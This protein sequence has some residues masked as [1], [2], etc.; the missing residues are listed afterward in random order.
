[1]NRVTLSQ[2]KALKAKAQAR[3][4]KRKANASFIRK[5]KKAIE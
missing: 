2:F 3:K 5:M 1:M 4:E